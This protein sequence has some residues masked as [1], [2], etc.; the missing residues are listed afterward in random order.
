M[1]AKCL[2]QALDAIPN[3]KIAN[4][5]WEEQFLPEIKEEPEL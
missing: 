3:S 2:V 1:Y 5:P 4:N